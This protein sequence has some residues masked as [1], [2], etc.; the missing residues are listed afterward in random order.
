MSLD[1]D[2][3]ASRGLLSWTVK[4]S[5]AVGIA[6]VL[7]G[8]TVARRSDPGAALVTTLDRDPVVTGSIGPA[9]R[10]TALDPCALRGR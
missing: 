9:A 7:L 2:P 4:V 3:R 1:A 6:A 8:H 5:L 10:A